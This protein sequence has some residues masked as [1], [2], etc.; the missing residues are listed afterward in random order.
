MQKI[1]K[2][3]LTIKW[4]KAEAWS[5]QAVRTPPCACMA[6]TLHDL[7]A[8]QGLYALLSQEL[9]YWWHSCHVKSIGYAKLH[10]GY[11]LATQWSHQ[12]KSP[13]NQM[14]TVHLPFWQWERRRWKLNRRLHELA[15][16]DVLFLFP[17]K[18]VPCHWDGRTALYNPFHIFSFAR[19]MKL[20]K[21]L[22]SGWCRTTEA[23]IQ[24]MYH[25]DSALVCLMLRASEGMKIEWWLPRLN[26]IT[27]GF[28]L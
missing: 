10:S 24:N 25:Q 8:L 23:I 14:D 2:I 16:K 5:S 11:S 21:L 6:L 26:I 3:Q 28:A 22:F 1:T 27:L 18:G 17:M 19:S 12:Q 9:K 4:C 15:G 20:L 7:G 13:W